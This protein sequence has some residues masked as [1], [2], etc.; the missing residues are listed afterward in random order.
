MSEV[1]TTVRRDLIDIL[2][3]PQCKGEVVPSGRGSGLICRTCSLLYPVRD[4]I[5]VMLVNEA[6]KLPQASAHA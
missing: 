4:G 1:L 5:P 3:C 2:A 6:V